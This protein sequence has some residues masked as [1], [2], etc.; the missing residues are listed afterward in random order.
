MIS[1]GNDLNRREFLGRLAILAG[2]AAVA[3]AGLPTSGKDEGSA[4]LTAKDD[5]R[6]AAESISYPA[7]TG[8]MKAYFAR[9]RGGG[10]YPGIVVIHENRGLNPHT[11]DVARRFALEGYLALAPDALSPFGGTPANPDDARPL[12]Q[13]LDGPSNIKNFTA[14]VRYLKTHPQ[15]TG[16]VACTGFC[17]GGGVTNQ[18]A[19][20]A[21]DL[22]AAIP[23]YGI[24]P[25]PEDVPKIKAALLLH[26]A[27]D[28]A[29]INAGIAA[30][31][32][33]LRKAGVDFR[34]HM[35]EGAGHA[36]FN[37]T[38][39]RYNKNAAELAWARTLAFLKEKL[40]T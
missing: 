3:G 30:Y 29:R 31:E 12:F 39:A 11:E 22:T 4:Q 32:E 27:G 24:Q 40:K 20:N 21:P 13:K 1:E 14:A 37:D 36:F 5:S 26:Y 33:A 2:G 25:A 19:V 9:P 28:D 17:W 18:V 6:L 34:T 15:S 38:G 16:K 8:E 10:K 23:F 7:E 35:Y